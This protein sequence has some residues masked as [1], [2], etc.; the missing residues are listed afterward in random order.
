MI[1]SHRLRAAVGNSGEQL[2]DIITTNLE[3]HI[4]FGFTSCYDQS[5]SYSAVSDLT[6]NGHN[7]VVYYGS[8]PLTSSN[9]SSLVVDT[10]TTPS[11]VNL[12]GVDDLDLRQTNDVWNNLGTGDYTLE[13]WLN[14]K[15]E[16]QTYQ[17]IW[18]DTTN[19]AAGRSIR[20]NQGKM[21]LYGVFNNSS[22]I[23][24]DSSA[25]YSTDGTYKGWE[26]LVFTRIGSGSNNFKFYRNNSLTFTGTDGNRSYTSSS[27]VSNSSNRFW[28]LLQYANFQLHGK[29]A[30]HR[31]YRGKGLTASEVTYN[32]NEQKARFG[33]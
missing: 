24:L 19:H 16:N 32:Y 13:F 7:M 10:G 21:G 25:Y 33:L 17:W 9:A 31:F 11:H 26:H 15:Q 1:L 29:F 18:I 6:S 30:I 14:I 22:D 4:D 20:I 2:P 23:D 27:F 5:T 8:N 28:G 3:Q 12:G